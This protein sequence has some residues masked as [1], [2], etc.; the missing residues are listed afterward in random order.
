M[1]LI[2]QYHLVK[3]QALAPADFEDGVALKTELAHTTVSVLV[4]DGSILI[5]GFEIDSE[6]GEDADNGYL[7]P[8]NEVLIP[9]TYL[10]PSMLEVIYE[11]G[12][13]DLSLFTQLVSEQDTY[14]LAENITV[15]APND[16]AMM[17]FMETNGIDDLADIPTGAVE[18]LLQMHVVSGI[19][20]EA[21]L[22]ADLDLT[23]TLDETLA[24]SE[25][26]ASI[27]IEA[28]T[29]VQSD[30]AAQ[31]GVVHKVDQVLLPGTEQS[32][33]GTY[34]GFLYYNINHQAYFENTIGTDAFGGLDSNDLTIM[35]PPDDEVSDALANSNIYDFYYPHYWS[36]ALSIDDIKDEEFIRS[37]WSLVTFYI[38]EVG[39]DLF[40][41]GSS[42]IIGE[43]S[44]NGGQYHIIFIDHHLDDGLN[45]ETIPDYIESRATATEDAE[46][47]VLWEAL[48]LGG[49][50]LGTTLNVFLAREDYGIAPFTIF[51]P[52]DA[53]FYDLFAEFQVQDLQGFISQEGLDAL[54]D[55]LFYSIA[56]DARIFTPD[57]MN[58]NSLLMGN[59]EDITVDINTLEITSQN[60]EFSL[61]LP[62]AT[63]TESNI[64]AT[65]GVIHVIDQVL[66]P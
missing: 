31:N 36:G 46:F 37:P 24:V 33:N 9:P 41:N 21:D 64:M 20:A 43:K 49:T 45:V 27:L 25:D 22:V 53:A 48:Q 55:I 60:Q 62:N 59:G 63:I 65:N 7:Y 12:E 3:G 30:L 8:L 54:D 6:N 10:L 4:N 16:N 52:T 26:N 11:E 18:R 58:D 38:S 66:L 44:F 42:K 15:F 13:D 51:A 39:E 35:V 1:V 50:G 2:L 23:T 40:I 19:Y 29:I 47:T 32:Y 34:A 61:S 14:F 5:N 57:F 28:G 17:A 56:S